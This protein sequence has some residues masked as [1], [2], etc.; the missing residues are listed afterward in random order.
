MPKILIIDDDNYLRGIYATIFSEAGFQSIEGADGAEGLK[1]AKAQKPDIIFTGIMMPNLT[2]FEM[3]K[4]L[5][6]DLS[7]GQ[8]P[9]IISSHLG[10]DDDRKEA[11]ALG[12][13]AFIIKGMF[14]PKQVVNLVL[15]LLNTRVTE[16]VYHVVVDAEK[17]D[18]SKLL[19]DLEIQ[20]P[21]TLELKSA[22]G[23]DKIFLARPLDAK[24]VQPSKSKADN[25]YNPSDILKN[26]E[27]QIGE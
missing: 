20:G 5:K 7:T 4:K 12:A 6:E 27:S 18:G 16:Q 21:L 3:M 25:S 14:S 8:I 11:E 23:K 17:I 10:R 24:E 13:K 1:L 26:I 15:E 9:V 19:R 2:G 22:G